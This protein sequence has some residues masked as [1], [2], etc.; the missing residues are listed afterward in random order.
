MTTLEELEQRLA[1]ATAA[2]LLPL[3][4][5]L[6]QSGSWAVILDPMRNGLVRVV[7]GTPC[8]EPE[9]AALIVAA[10]NALPGLLES[11]RRV[12]R[13]EAALRPIADLCDWI[14]IPDDDS[15]EVPLKI[16]HIVTARAAL[17]AKGA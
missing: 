2:G 5:A 10:I 4:V 3:S 1:V 7:N 15:R 17:K 8:F 12:E 9:E 13:L 6:D 11:A 14:G 16:R